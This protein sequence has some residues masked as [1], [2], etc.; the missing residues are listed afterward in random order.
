MRTRKAITRLIAT[1][2]VLGA[3]AA[4]LFGANWLRSVEAEDGSVRFVSYATIGM[5]P[6]QRMRL[7]AANSGGTASVSMSL[8]YYLAHG[9]NSQN[10]VP[11]HETEL[12]QVPR[13]EFRFSELSRRELNTE[14][15]RGTGRAQVIVS[16]TIIAPAGS[17]PDD[18]PTSLEVTDDEEQTVQTDSKY[19]LILVA[20]RRSAQ[21]A[22]I[23]LIPG[24]RLSYTVFN[25]NDEGSQP[26]RVRAYGYDAIGRLVTKTDPVE[27]RPGQSYTANLDS[28]DLRVSGEDETGRLM[29]RVE[30]RVE[31][32]DGS[33]STIKLPVSM[34]LVDKH[35]GRTQ[36]GSYFAGTVSVSGDGFDG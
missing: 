3:L 26:V 36:G 12:I 11:F 29:I 28:A 9:N 16:L 10:H 27:L 32:M 2:M 4:G 18:F 31:L 33:E 19:R 22:P 24:Q 25:P 7:V 21:L 13:G 14:G 1:T 20:A 23:S 5:V 35:T 17:H 34:E 8:Q 30:T 15:E 6:G